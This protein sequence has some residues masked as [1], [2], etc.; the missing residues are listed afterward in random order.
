[1]I[2]RKSATSMIAAPP[3]RFKTGLAL[4]LAAKWALEGCTVLYVAADS[5]PHTV[6]KR[7]AGILTGDDIE[8]IE[9]VIKQGAYRNQLQ[10]LSNIHSSSRPW[11]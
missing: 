5:D 8:A 4:N 11:T 7:C 10:R 3:G 9:P 1:M 6:A 2:F